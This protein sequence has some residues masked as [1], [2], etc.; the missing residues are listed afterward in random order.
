M[1]DGLTILRIE[2]D[3]RSIPAGKYFLGFRRRPWDW[4][5]IP[6]VLE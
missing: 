2:M 4:T 3:L 1:N 5:Y 6:I